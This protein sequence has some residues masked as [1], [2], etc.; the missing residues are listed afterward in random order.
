LCVKGRRG[1][2]CGVK[3][4]RLSQDQKRVP[5]LV[6]GIFPAVGFW[7]DRSHFVWIWADPS[8]S[9]SQSAVVD[10]LMKNGTKHS[11]TVD[12]PYGSPGN[13]LGWDGEIAK[14]RTCS[15]LSARP[16]S[17]DNIEKVIDMCMH[18]EEI[19]DVTHIVRLLS[20]ST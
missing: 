6:G 17:T 19:S 20:A 10:I 14:F 12:H 8:L 5:G 9:V 16:V 18:L 1:A 13:P 7:G 3:I 4:K 2:T 11:H 15:S